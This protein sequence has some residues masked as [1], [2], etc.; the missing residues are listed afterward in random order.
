MNVSDEYAALL[1][2]HHWQLDDSKVGET[3][4]F[5]GHQDGMVCANSNLVDWCNTSVLHGQ[6]CYTCNT[7]VA[8]LV[9]Q[10]SKNTTHILFNS[11][12]K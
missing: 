9:V 11:H 1:Q 10:F 4:I 3:L 8:H 12:T 7:H 6:L 5:A 2:D